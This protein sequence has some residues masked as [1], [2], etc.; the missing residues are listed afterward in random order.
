MTIKALEQRRKHEHI[1][2]IYLQDQLIGEM[3]YQLDT[4]QLYKEEP[5]PL[6]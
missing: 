2:L 3:G 1:Y 5:E 4:K 6:G